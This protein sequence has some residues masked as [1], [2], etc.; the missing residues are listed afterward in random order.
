VRIRVRVR[1][2]VRVRDRDRIRVRVRDRVKVRVGVRVR[3]RVRVSTAGRSF[4]EPST[5]SK[6][7]S[8]PTATCTVRT[9]VSLPSASPTN[10]RERIE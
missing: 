4:S 1:V 7:P 10:S 3:V 9:A 6:L 5:S 8:G 2:R